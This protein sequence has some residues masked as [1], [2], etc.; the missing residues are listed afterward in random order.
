MK[1]AR[2]AQNRL[3][4][5]AGQVGL[6]PENCRRVQSTCVQAAAL[7]GSELWWKEKTPT[8]W[9]A[10]E[11]MSKSWSTRRQGA[12][13][14]ESGTKPAAAQLDNRQRR[15]ASGSPASQGATRPENSWRPQTAPSESDYNSP[16]D[17]GTAEKTR[18]SSRWP[19]PWTHPPR[20][21]KRPQLRGRRTNQTGLA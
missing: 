4:R 1:K 6:S 5:H 7:F 18:S 19:P 10:G 15:F 21:M 12:L 16:S 17:V 13:S 11:R 8:A 3:R 9:S 14:L 20:S 2:N